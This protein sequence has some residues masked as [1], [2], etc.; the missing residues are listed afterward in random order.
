MF[1]LKYIPRMLLLSV[2]YNGAES[3]ATSRA[4]GRVGEWLSFC[5]QRQTHSMSSREGGGRSIKRR[6]LWGLGVFRKHKSSQDY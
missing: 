1:S 2:L 4:G 5:E 3:V 6:E